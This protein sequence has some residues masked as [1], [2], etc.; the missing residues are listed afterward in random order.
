[1]TRSSFQ[2]NIKTKF[3]ACD[4]LVKKVVTFGV[5]LYLNQGPVNGILHFAELH[6]DSSIRYKKTLVGNYFLKCYKTKTLYILQLFSLVKY[7]QLFILYNA[8][9]YV[10]LIVLSHLFLKTLDI[11]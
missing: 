2:Q 1:M 3:I 4:F 5:V 10:V 6:I 9:G 8:L 11:F 7:G